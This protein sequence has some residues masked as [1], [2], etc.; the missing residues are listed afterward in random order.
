MLLRKPKNLRELKV[1]VEMYLSQ[2]D[3]SFLPA[4]PEK[5][6]RS[7]EE[8]VRG[9]AYM[10]V[11]VDDHGSVI[12][13]LLAI[14]GNHPHINGRVLQQQ[15]YTSNKS[16]VIAVRLLRMMHTDLVREAK[17]RN[18]STVV[19]IASHMDPT[20]QLCRILEKDGWVSRGFLAIYKVTN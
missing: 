9:G 1:C 3:E 8:L 6:L 15:Y 10:R 12:S 17:I 20:F 7:L 13:W 2:N 19:S 18:I 11:V 14:D 5:S 16:G 4:N